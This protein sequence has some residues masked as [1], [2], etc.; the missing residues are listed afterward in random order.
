M[1]N[2]EFSQDDYSYIY[3]E[4]A[5]ITSIVPSEALLFE[6]FNASGYAS[7]WIKSDEY[8]GSGITFGPGEIEVKNGKLYLGNAP[9]RPNSPRVFLIPESTLILISGLLDQL[10]DLS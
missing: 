8:L 6:D 5:A 4:D 9:A 1:F 3:N 10:E 7:S 2:R